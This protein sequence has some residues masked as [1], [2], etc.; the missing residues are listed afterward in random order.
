[1]V[2]RIRNNLLSQ[3]AQPHP[4]LCRA[5]IGSPRPLFR[6]PK[7]AHENC[8]APW[9]KSS[10]WSESISATATPETSN[11]QS[12]RHSFVPD[13]WCVFA[14]LLAHRLTALPF[15]AI[16]FKSSFLLFLPLFCSCDCLRQT[17]RYPHRRFRATAVVVA[18]PERSLY[19]LRRAWPTRS[20]RSE[21]GRVV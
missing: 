19:L 9:P 17:R 13:W 15:V 18:Q 6:P 21:T 5:F 20:A 2:L 12:C 10:I 8:K 3:M 4:C 16:D 11:T 1:M 7:W 14:V